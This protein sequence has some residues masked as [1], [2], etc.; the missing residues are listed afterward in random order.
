MKILQ[1]IAL[2]IFAHQLSFAQN[3]NEQI[4]FIP[5]RLFK[6]ESYKKCGIEMTP[7][8]LIQVFRD[9]PNMTKF[10][11]PLVMN[12]VGETLLQAAGGVLI[13]WPL[14]EAI[15]KDDPNWNL[16]YIGAACYVVA[17][18]FQKG[19]SKNAKSAIAYYNNGY[20]ETSRVNFNLQM[21]SNGLGLAMKF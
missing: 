8:Q 12:Y 1:A 7:T 15:Y 6:N 2:I 4:E 19:F 10:V 16:A 18:P 13:L 17:I 20:Q 3:S 21:G 5:K 9:D 14:T 11:K